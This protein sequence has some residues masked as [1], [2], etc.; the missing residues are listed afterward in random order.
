M[1]ATKA[2]AGSI[3]IGV[4]TELLLTARSIEDHGRDKRDFCRKVAGGYM[5]TLDSDTRIKHPGMH[6]AIDEAYLGTQFAEWSLDSDITIVTPDKK[7]APCKCL[8]CAQ[9]RDFG[10]T[11]GLFSAP[12]LRSLNAKIPSVATT[13]TGAA[14]TARETHCTRR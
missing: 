12:H 4:E 3:G 10:I 2:P 9:A 8:F 7:S 6:N 5:K 13:A 11:R 14:L 1:H